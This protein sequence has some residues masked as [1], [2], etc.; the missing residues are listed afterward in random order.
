MHSSETPSEV[1]V[2]S[3]CPGKSFRTKRDAKKHAVDVHVAEWRNCSYPDCNYR[4]RKIGNLKSHEIRVHQAVKAKN[5]KDVM[6]AT[7]STVD[8]IGAEEEVWYEEEVAPGC[9]NEIA[10]KIINMPSNYF[11]N[12]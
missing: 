10:P 1:H 3:M 12:R 8:D 7:E 9:S 6:H 4:S 2:C 11:F 5:S